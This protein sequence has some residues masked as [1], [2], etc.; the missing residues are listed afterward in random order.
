MGKQVYGRPDATGAGTRGRR[1]TVLAAALLAACGLFLTGCGA[2]LN[3][4]LAV[5][6][7]QQKGRSGLSAGPGQSQ[8][9]AVRL[10]KAADAFASAATPGSAAYKIGP[11]D[12]LDISVFKAP[13]LARSVQVAESGSINL[14]L[15]GEIHAVGKTAQEV[16]RD[17]A[18]RLGA[19]YMQSPQVTVYVKEF[20]S[21]RVT[22]EGAVKKPGIYPLRGKTTLMQSLAMAEGLDPTS[23]MSNVVIFRRVEGKRFAAKFDVT[24]IRAGKAEDPTIM[25]GDLIVANAS[26]MKAAWQDLLRALPVG[27][28]FIPLL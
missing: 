25:Q 17:L 26:A 24:E 4:E 3:S 20:N 27:A 15:V 6:D 1:A 16:E 9:N 19:K 10:P 5:Q 21:Q 13:E 28:A 8:E 7:E 23:D 18:K 11:Q 2:S 14:P 12:V 22:V